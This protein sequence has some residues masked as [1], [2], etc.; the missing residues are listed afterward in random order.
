MTNFDFQRIRKYTG[1]SGEAVEVRPANEIYQGQGA[2][3][4]L[5]L[6]IQCGCKVWV[7]SDYPRGSVRS[8]AIPK[9]SLLTTSPINLSLKPKNRDMPSK[10]ILDLMGIVLRALARVEY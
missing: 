10:Y 4:C 1:S 2:R 5:Q 8:C 9:M 7:N 3:K 6:S